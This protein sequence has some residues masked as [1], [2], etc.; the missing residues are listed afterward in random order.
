[1]ASSQQAARIKWKVKYYRNVVCKP[2]P[3][4]IYPELNQLQIE[5]EIIRLSE[6]RESGAF[7]EEDLPAR[8]A[9]LADRYQHAFPSA[10]RSDERLDA[11][12]KRTVA[13]KLR[14]LDV[15]A[16]AKLT[17]FNPA[18]LIEPTGSSIA[19]SKPLETE[20]EKA[21][22]ATCD[23]FEARIRDAASEEDRAR[24]QKEYDEYFEEY[25]KRPTSH[26]TR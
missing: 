24:L 25:K 18:I 8:I 3:I 5:R 14:Q 17:S 2:I 7:E 16:P 10:G 26:R 13:D 4:D 6:F 15:T 22:Y 21:H 20:E 12:I 19:A 11:V 1:M 9:W 23:L